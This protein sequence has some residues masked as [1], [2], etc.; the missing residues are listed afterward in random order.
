[1]RRR[2]LRQWMVEFAGDGVDP[3]RT[4]AFR[5]GLAEHPDLAA[6]WAQLSEVDHALAHLPRAEL[7]DDAFF[8]AL[9]SRIAA[10]IDRL[11]AAPTGWA[12]L[13][14]LALSGALAALLLACLGLAVWLDRAPGGAPSG[15]ADWAVTPL[16]PDANLEVALGEADLDAEPWSADD[17]APPTATERR[18][19][20]PAPEPLLPPAADARAEPVPDLLAPRVDVVRAPTPSA[21]TRRS[22]VRPTTTLTGRREMPR[23]TP[24]AVAVA[25]LPPASPLGAA[26]RR[27][28][29]DRPAPT[30]PAIRSGSGI[31]PGGV[32]RPPAEGRDGLTATRPTRMATAPAAPANER[33][34]G[35]AEPTLPTVQVGQPP[36]L[37]IAVATTR[38]AL[39]AETAEPAAASDA[40][41]AREMRGALTGASLQ[42]VPAV[43]AA[44]RVPAAAPG[45]G[46]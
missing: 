23:P 25:A 7:P 37:D 4:D 3:A 11:S 43:S 39:L 28:P 38:F 14:R 30:S 9:E 35:P 5:A 8:A 20:Q 1:M 2:M 32:A 31:G 21:A 12:W 19:P 42:V 41:H 45:Q 6:E 26:A 27:E 24:P 44:R 22:P 15:S 40:E 33:P 13:P 34:G 46:R 29:T 10:D 18:T 17:L 16:A 36:R